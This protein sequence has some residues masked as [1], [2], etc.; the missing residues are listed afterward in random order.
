MNVS[1]EF[2]RGYSFGRRRIVNFL[3]GHVSEAQF[4]EY[5]I[6]EF[7]NGEPV[8]KIVTCYPQT[9]PLLDNP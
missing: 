1:C 2:L 6:L 9:V 7:C 4:G 8:T 5:G 3:S